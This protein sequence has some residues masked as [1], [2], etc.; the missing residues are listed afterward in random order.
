MKKL[1]SILSIAAISFA[2]ITSCAKEEQAS[3]AEDGINI[4]VIASDKDVDNDPSKTKTY[5]SEDGNTVHVYWQ[6]TDRLRVY[7]VLDGGG[8]VY[9]AATKK[10]TVLDGGKTA[11]FEA[12]LSGSVTGEHTSYVYTAIYP[13]GCVSKSGENYRVLIPATQ[14]LKETNLASDADV[15]IG[16]PIDK[17]NTRIK[18]G[19]VL[20]YQFKRYGTTVKMTLK[21]ITASEKLRK[22]EI[23]APVSMA[24]YGYVDLTTGEIT[25]TEGTSTTMTLNVNDVVVDETGNIPV[26][27]RVLSNTW[28]A[29]ESKPIQITVTTDKATY[30]K[31]I[32]SAEL[33]FADG[34]LT[35]FGISNLGASREEIQ[36]LPN[37]DYVITSSVDEN[38]YIMMAYVDGNNIP[39]ETYTLNDEQKIVVNNNN[40]EKCVYTFT[41]VSDG[42]YKGCYTIMDYNGKYLYAAGSG[43]NNYLRAADLN[44]GNAQFFWTYT[45]DGGLQAKSENRN[46]LQYNSSSNFF[47]CYNGTQKPISIVSADNVVVNKVPKIIV[48]ATSL[49]LDA[50]GNNKG[51][52]ITVTGVNLTDEITTTVDNTCDWLIADVEDGVLGFV[53]ESNNG[54]EERNTNITLSSE[55]ATSVVISVTQ[56]SNKKA[57]EINTTNSGVTGSYA[58]KTFDVDDITFGFTNWMKNTNIQAKASTTNSLYNEDA[59]PAPITKITFVQ[60]GTAKAI[61]VYGGTSKKPTT[62]ITAPT[63][64]ATMV[65]DFTGKEYTYFSMT[66]PGNAVYFDKI[67][68]EYAESAKLTSIVVSGTPTKTSYK[69]GDKFETAGLVA[70]ATYD[71]ASEKDVTDDVEWK[72]TP[73]PLTVE[74]TSVSVVAT[75][76]GVSSTAKEITDINVTEPA[77]L[78][79]ISIKTAPTKIVYNEGEEF[80]PTGLVIYRHYSDET[81]D[82]YAY[83]GHEDDFEFSPALSTPLAISNTS[84]TITYGGKSVSQ[85]ITV[86]DTSL[87]T[88][89]EIFAAATSTEKDAK[90]KF[91]NWVVSGVKGSTAYVTDGTKGLIIYTS[92]HGFVSG[93]I[94]SGTVSCKLVKYSGASELKGVTTSTDGLSVTKGG[95]ITP[96]TIS[97]A[98]LSGVN[99]G[100]V[101]TFESLKYNGSDFTDGVNTIKPYNGIM[102]QLPTLTSGRNYCVTGVYVQYNSTKEI[103]PR[104]AEDIEEI[105]AP[106]YAVSIA[107]GITNGTVTVDCTEATE[108]Q[109]VTITATPSTGYKVKSVSAKKTASGDALTVTNN[110]FTMPAEAVTV[111]AEFEE[112]G[113]GGGELKTYSHIFSTKPNTGNNIS[114]SN[115]AWNIAAE[116]LNNYN[117]GYAGVQFGTSSKE[118]SITLTSSSAWSYQSATNI[119]EI[120]VWI[121]TGGGTIT[122]TVSIGGTNV[123]SDGTTISKKSSLNND[124]T[125]ANKVTFKPSSSLTGVVVIKLEKKTAKEAAGYICAIEIDAN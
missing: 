69:A 83:A 16:A 40:A 43:S 26:W 9:Y 63:A 28:N 23:K 25:K 36:A 37:G 7:E 95:T 110:K 39:R 33:V 113:Q 4:T 62:E 80:D 48:S 67:T 32:K 1:F 98:D 123:A 94:L 46:I 22:V 124:Y 118:G 50:A 58:T 115:I 103:A 35:I 73:T 74:T 111:S 101:I 41:C 19:D 15:L 44:T 29:T 112:A 87:K 72:V 82:D 61:K 70:T 77:T 85:D 75:Y 53:A 78:E 18:A 47:S 30:S 3:V 79:S 99:T 92:K 104:S 100:A 88:M 42:D 107:A 60:T 90:I 54:D 10:T 71:D 52:D 8:Q 106:T 121:N 45:G 119:K 55:G 120:R 11:E 93:D 105:A 91:G 2:A 13:E 12:N 114:L 116:N 84:V 117:S 24:G 108:G 96:A 21:G 31:E 97:I 125:K 57:I 20:E 64:A 89:D 102:D 27:F 6:E 5:V 86:N 38:K 51:D 17:G 14:N 81:K 56:K 66:T 65:F 122:P 109:T 34:G 68:I 76:K 59:I 49:T